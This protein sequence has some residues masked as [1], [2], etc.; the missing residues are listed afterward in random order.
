M[1]INYPDE[2]INYELEKQII[3]ALINIP[4]NV[5]NLGRKLKPHHFYKKANNLVFSL[6]YEASSKK[7]KIGR[8]FIQNELKKNKLLSDWI[9]D[10]ATI[11]DVN[12]LHKIADEL[13]DL[14]N[15]RNL[16]KATETTKEQLLSNE[17]DIV[18]LS[19][20]LITSIAKS[21]F[22]QK[23]TSVSEIMKLLKSEMKAIQEGK[24]LRT[25]FEQLD[26]IV[27]PFVA[28]HLWLIGAMTSTGKTWVLLQLIKNIIEQKGKVALFS[29]EMRSYENLGRIIGNELGDGFNKMWQPTTGLNFFDTPK[30]KNYTNKINPYLLIYDDIRSVKEV[31]AEI[32]SM[33][34]NEGVDICFIDFIQ[35]VEMGQK[36][37]YSAMREVA[38]EVQRIAKELKVT[39]VLASQLSNSYGA[40]GSSNA[41]VEYKNAGELAAAADVGIMLWDHKKKYEENMQRAEYQL[42]YGYKPILLDVKKSRHTTTGTVPMIL[43]YPSGRII[44]CPPKWDWLNTERRE[45]FYQSQQ[46]E[47]TQQKKDV[48]TE[49]I[50]DIFG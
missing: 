11:F 41:T 39:M 29:T 38:L 47:K 4:L 33:V 49:V 50:D 34:L 2:L 7:Q 16:Y 26:L 8:T 24:G 15:R 9:F 18:R 10:K 12:E 35:N 3:L 45:D 36:D 37:P 43:E 48:F 6:I 30:V 1:K 13:I 42:P 23:P 14:A 28:G 46:E 20:E 25:G 19:S 40:K 44:E 31:S 17:K 21:H 5:L 27:P 22:T 32:R